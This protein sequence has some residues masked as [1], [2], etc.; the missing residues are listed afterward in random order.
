MYAISVKKFFFNSYLIE[1]GCKL[2][3]VDAFLLFNK[4]IFAIVFIE[5]VFFA[6]LE[7]E[8]GKEKEHLHLKLMLN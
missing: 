5:I 7:N 8:R 6:D 4:S 3:K 2:V 1:I